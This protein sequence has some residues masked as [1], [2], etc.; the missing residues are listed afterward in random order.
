MPTTPEKLQVG[1]TDDLRFAALTNLIYEEMRR[2]TNEKYIVSFH[3]S[4]IDDPVRERIRQ[5]Y[6]SSG[7]EVEFLTQPDDFGVFVKL[8]PTNPIK[9]D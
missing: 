1:N 2:C 5:Y 9:K 6:Q 3:T 8:W 7:W 4:P